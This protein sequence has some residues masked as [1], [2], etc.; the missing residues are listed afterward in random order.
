V[1]NELFQENAVVGATR[2]EVR[3]TVRD[4]IGV[5]PTKTV[6]KCDF[7]KK[8][9]VLPAAGEK[10]PVPCQVTLAIGTHNGPATREIKLNKKIML[11]L[12][13]GIKIPPHTLRGDHIGRAPT[14]R[15]GVDGE[16]SRLRPRRSGA[17][18]PPTR[19]IVP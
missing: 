13:E 2:V 7:S 14:T 16:A 11:G 15:R 17:R 19:T 4:E 10:V 9:A 5:F 6:D 18:P 3:V 12:G 1:L 8:K